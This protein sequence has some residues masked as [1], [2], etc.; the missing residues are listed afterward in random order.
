MSVMIFDTDNGGA[1]KRTSV[2]GREAQGIVPQIA[3]G[4]W[5]LRMTVGRPFNSW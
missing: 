4:I 5:L 2:R 1:Q 3:R